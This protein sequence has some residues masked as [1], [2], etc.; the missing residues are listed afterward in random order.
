MDGFAG[1]VLSP[2]VRTSEQ[3]LSE[4]IEPP[5]GSNRPGWHRA[6]GDGTSA[7]WGAVEAFDP[8]AEPAVDD[9]LRQIE[10]KEADQGAAGS[11]AEQRALSEMTGSLHRPNGT[12]SDHQQQALQHQ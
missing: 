1:P 12:E 10:N 11:D 5:N 2:F 7:R 9:D 6:S 3:S 4:Q 8:L